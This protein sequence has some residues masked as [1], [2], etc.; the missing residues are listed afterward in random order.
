VR[1]EVSCAYRL[2]ALR[3]RK[4]PMFFFPEHSP[5]LLRIFRFRRY[6]ND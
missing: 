3:H 1:V 4:N 2:S 6:R 5:A